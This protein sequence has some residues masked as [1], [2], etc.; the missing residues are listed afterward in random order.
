M[1]RFF[2]RKNRKKR[3]LCALSA[4]LSV[5]LTLGVFAACAPTES[6]PEEDQPST[7]TPTDAHRIKNS[8][9][10][11]FAEMNKEFSEK[12]D[13]IN[14]PSSY[15]WTFSTA[16]T[17]KAS[18]GIIKTDE[19]AELA[20][21]KT[22]LILE[23]DRW[24]K[25]SDSDAYKDSEG[26]KLD[27]SAENGGKRIEATSGTLSDEAAQNAL[28]H[29]ENTTLR[30][31]IE[32]Y[33]FYGI[34]SEEEFEK[35]ETDYYTIKFDDI[36][37]FADLK[38]GDEPVDGP[39]LHDNAKAEGENAETGVL[40]IHNRYD[41]DDKYGT[42]QHYS[43]TSVTLSA[44]TAAVLS[45]WVKTANLVHFEN[46]P[47]DK[48]AGAYIGVIPTV[49]G[50]TLK[51]VQIKNI[52]TEKYDDLE[53]TNGWKQYSVYL[54]ANTFATTTFRVELGLGLGSSTQRTEFVDGYAFFDDLTCDI[55]SNHDYE[56]ATTSI[57][58]TTKVWCGLND[59]GT[60]IKEFDIV[61]GK[62]GD[63]VPADTFNIDLASIF[64]TFSEWNNDLTSEEE[65]Y[66]KSFAVEGA[67]AYLTKEKLNNKTYTSQD[68]GIGDNRGT[69]IPEE[70]QSIVGKYSLARLKEWSTNGYAANILE[71]DFT[72]KFPFSSE[73]DGNDD[74]IFILSTNGAAYTVELPEW[75]VAPNSRELISFFV[76]TS[77]LRSGAYGAGAKLVDG[78]ETA[79]SSISPFN[80]TLVATVDIDDKDGTS[81]KDI[82]DGWVQCFFF[83]QNDTEE[84]KQ[85]HLE[86]TYGPT[87][88][89]SATKDDY[90]MGYAA[91]ANFRTSKLTTTQ[92]SYA[93]TGT[94]AQKV[95][96]T[97]ESSNS[98]KFD[99]A[100][101]SGTSIEKG[102]ATPANYQGVQAG[103]DRL[104]AG[105]T[106]NPTRKE[107]E[108]KG[109]Y[110]GLLSE[111]YADKYDTS[112]PWAQAIGATSGDWW[113][114][115][116][117]NGKDGADPVNQ[118]L[119]VVN[120]QENM[121]AYGFTNG[122]KATFPANSAARVRVR[123]KLSENL[124][125]YLYLIDTSDIKDEKLLSSTL[126]KYTF[127]YDED[128]NI[129]DMDPSDKD[130][131]TEH[132][133]WFIRQEN[134][135]YKNAKDANDA[136][137]YANLSAYDTDDDGN[138]VTGSGTIAYYAHDGKFYA[139]YDKDSAT[140]YTQEVHDLTK[141][142]GIDEILRYDYSATEKCEG[143]LEIDG[144]KFG[145]EWVT[146]YFYIQ[147]GNQAKNYRFELWAG[148]RDDEGTGIP[149][150]AY[151]FFDRIDIQTSY[152]NYT[153]DRD[154]AVEVL[155]RKANLGEKDH[156]TEN[157]LYYT[158]S[159]FDSPEYLRYDKT[160]D[161][162]N[163]GD[164]W[165][166]YDQSAY[167]EN[168]VYL[169]V[170]DTARKI[171]ANFPSVSKFISFA[172]NEVTVDRA[173]TDDTDTTTDTEDTT[174]DEGDGSEL[175]LSLVSIFLVLALVFAI[176][177]VVI[178]KFYKPKKKQEG[179]P[180]KKR[181]AAKR[182]EPAPEETPA[183]NAP[184][185]DDSD[186]PYGE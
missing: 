93:A 89:A 78:D 50:T 123:M 155:K 142:A 43:S 23:S 133:V 4:A 75:K 100:A 161:T 41:S 55:I 6:S 172:A 176:V 149:K 58:E 39:G 16:V 168:L 67:D 66:T 181:A 44:G 9:F 180:A 1:A 74:I 3:W 106:P 140:P 15:N 25:A 8:N 170:E 19:W 87:S 20:T 12:H 13:F 151:A 70:R 102:L 146:A 92:Y 96:L 186:G 57:G 139:Y 167:E 31:R 136:N 53:A 103:S 76:K 175:W 157:A 141:V 37:D 159:F 83:V 28:D 108:D 5:T 2:D 184:A 48:R 18:S 68:V 88:V 38:Q 64:G 90:C 63:P 120:T 165:K 40:M 86:L 27:A 182:T 128:G 125:A 127:W 91:F 24:Q 14:N 112:A 21:S 34:D 153:A 26:F 145:E 163:V 105:G 35:Y 134:G 69:S 73:T 119:I 107:L 111:Q 174:D 148:A 84:V 152:S 116:F 46:D 121:P 132:T 49:G 131:K 97:A 109:F 81:G 30:D 65:N 32:F 85:Y 77:E 158:F 22:S 138:L 124:K 36:K 117:G 183:K 162:E 177:A 79:T 29:W 56:A 61:D 10:E 160:E 59:L 72:D 82:Y 17:S 137:L 71:K 169:Y 101:A 178:R 62:T 60:D 51:A 179:G 110:T 118:P 45:V 95:S 115:V 104:V 164:P 52:V 11:F 80:S 42:A 135:L 113:T 166:N 98:T 156:L 150:G 143:I 154:N 114:T 171:H 99:D 47:V 54:R 7:P 126:P 33:S 129:V 144:S 173:V 147:T 185:D 122:T 94:Y 130:F